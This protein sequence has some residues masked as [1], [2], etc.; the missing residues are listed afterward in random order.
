MNNSIGH[1][2]Q[3]KAVQFKGSGFRVNN[4]AGFF[5]KVYHFQGWRSSRFIGSML[6]NVM[7]ASVLAA[8]TVT[9][10]E[11]GAPGG[12]QARPMRSMNYGNWVGRRVMSAEFI[13]KVGI[14]EEQVAK[15]KASMEEVEKK[16]K[17]LEAEI[18]K[19]SIAQAQLAKKILNEPGADAAEIMAIIEK[20][21]QLRTEQAKT[22]TRILIN[23]RDTLT[24]EQRKTASETIAEE[25]RKRM[26]ERQQRRQREEREPRRGPG[27]AAPARPAVPQGW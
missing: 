25:G 6:R 22:N 4:K 18:N 9:G 24:E 27:P 8:G 20:I 10:Q 2:Q 11:R 19:L 17:G 15:L 13:D 23:I 5:M 14:T 7:L 21:G 1:L 16:Q 26:Q 12:Q 3:L